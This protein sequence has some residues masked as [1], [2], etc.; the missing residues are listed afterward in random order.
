MELRSKNKKNPDQVSS[1]S[2]SNT[3]TIEG[4]NQQTVTNPSAERGHNTIATEGKT[5]IQ[6]KLKFKETNMPGNNPGNTPNKTP[7]GSG[8]GGRRGGPGQPEAKG[9]G[10]MTLDS[11]AT[12]ITSTNKITNDKIDAVQLE[13]TQFKQG[14]EQWQNVTDE[15]LKKL[16]KIKDAVENKVD[17]QIRDITRI[18]SSNVVR[19]NEMRAI[20]LEN[21]QL[22]EQLILTQ[23]CVKKLST[24]ANMYGRTIRDYN[25]RIG[26]MKDALA[27]DPRGNSSG[28]KPR[29][30]TKKLVVDFIMRKNLS[31]HKPSEIAIRD[32]I[33][34][35]YRTGSVENNRTRV[36]LVKFM[37]LEDKGIV[38]R[39][40][41]Q[42]ER[43]NEM[44]GVYMKDDYTMEDYSQKRR[45]H[46]IMKDLKD[47]EKKPFFGNGRLKC[48]EGT[49]KIKDVIE[50]NKQRGIVDPR[51]KEITVDKLTLQNMPRP[52]AKKVQEIKDAT[53][54]ADE[55]VEEDTTVEGERDTAE[56]E[57]NKADSASAPLTQFS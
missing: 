8:G 42:K 50:Y 3:Y 26:G 46:A 33:D 24:E 56:D 36:I 20:R 52:K 30:D 27:P 23:A 54:Q 55:M 13:L 2:N 18:D 41:K 28:P 35:A 57:S 19:E 7:G 5:L 37:R 9:R 25:I 11:L 47:K 45:C 44:E 53:E 39:E 6:T 51:D 48:I 10:E 22:R 40:A 16:E 31:P 29:E 21:K 17:A 49:I 14:I 15:R 12:L 4:E 34:V 43:A 38:M 1:N 32:M